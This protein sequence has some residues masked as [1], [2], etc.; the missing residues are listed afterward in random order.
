MS[1]FSNFSSFKPFLLRLFV[2][3]RSLG[4]LPAHVS[5]QLSWRNKLLLT[6]FTGKLFEMPNFENFFLLLLATTLF[7]HKWVKVFI[8]C[9]ILFLEQQRIK[10]IYRAKTEFRVTFIVDWMNYGVILV[11]DLFNERSICITSSLRKFI[12][13]V[14]FRNRMIIVR[15]GTFE[16]KHF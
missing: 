13:C 3:L 2:F 16:I 12:F 11:K 4:V 7:D 15:C 5:S 10:T 14:F 6:Y 9:L 8:L 1:N